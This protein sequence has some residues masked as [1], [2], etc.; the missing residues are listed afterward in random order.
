MGGPAIRAELLRH[1]DVVGIVELLTMQLGYKSVLVTGRIDL[2][3]SLNAEQVEALMSRLGDDLR[4][5]VPDVHNVYL[6]PRSHS[7][8]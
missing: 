3:D 2:R 1:P 8:G 6:E 5:A 7:Q 4:N